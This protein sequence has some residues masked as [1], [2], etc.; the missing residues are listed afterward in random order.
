MEAKEE[1][2]DNN[3]GPV[4]REDLYS[5]NE[6][7]QDDIVEA[8]NEA[9]AKEEYGDE[10]SEKEA[11]INDGVQA[12]E[13]EA[14]EEYGEKP[15]EDE[16]VAKEDYGDEHSEKEADLYDGVQ[17]KE[18]EHSEK[19]AD[20]YDGVQAKEDERSEKEEAD[21]YDGVQ[22]KED[23]HSEK[24]ADH[25]DGVIGVQVKEEYDGNET[26]NNDGPVADESAVHDDAVEAKK[27]EETAAEADRDDGVEAKK[28]E[29]SKGD[30]GHDDP[31][32][33]E[34]QDLKN[35][36][37]D[38]LPER[39][40]AEN[41]DSAEVG[42][43]T[44][45][46]DKDKVGDD[47][48][49]TEVPVSDGTHEAVQDK[50]EVERDEEVVY[51]D[52]FEEE[53]KKEDEKIVEK[54]ADESADLGEPDYKSTKEKESLESMGKKKGSLQDLAEPEIDAVKPEEAIEE[55]RTD[56]SSKQPQNDFEDDDGSKRES[57]TLAEANQV[58]ERT[59]SGLLDSK[60]GISAEELIKTEDNH[61]TVE[62]FEP[63]SMAAAEQS[64][65]LD[66]DDQPRAGSLTPGGDGASVKDQWESQS[67]A[68]SEK[69]EDITDEVSMPMLDS[70]STHS[71]ESEASEL[72]AHHPNDRPVSPS[73]K[74]EHIITAEV[75]EVVLD[76]STNN[77]D[78]TEV[79]ASSIQVQNSDNDVPTVP[80]TSAENTE[81]GKP[82]GDKPVDDA[83]MMGT[84]SPHSIESNPLHADVDKDESYSALFA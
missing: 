52:H 69:A 34:D 68:P 9:V 33:R 8:K 19:E 74:T 56:Y 61:D 24:E 26:G 36:N 41:D 1:Y 39:F 11:D 71:K 23:E 49:I 55:E 72:A 65:L 63:E 47:D 81:L 5:E 42:K 50:L 76:E 66:K 37:G 46:N 70:D 13:D 28:D 31:E 43:E 7:N 79:I 75:P 78:Q 84:E 45:D 38:I 57:Q 29:E 27:D 4:A 14:K 12:T 3:D 18:D 64:E 60:N 51:S 67:I 62:K 10:H 2:G 44:S 16:A 48:H 59:G 21:L 83:V 30:A 6:A 53:D 80:I 22:A 25:N 15:K 54:D 82:Y 58:L 17:A 35:D 20:L 40:G 77:V 73:G 32:A